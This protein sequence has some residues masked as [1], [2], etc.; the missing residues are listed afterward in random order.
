[1]REYELLYIASGALTEDEAAKVTDEV[2]SAL[3]AV[4]GKVADE[5][6][7]GRRRLAY[8]VAKQEHGW[9]VVSR[10]TLEGSKVT[11]FERALRLN[12]S[13]IRTL[14]LSA[15][16][17]PTAEEAEK[18]AK[19]ASE[20]DAEREDRKEKPK[21][22][23]ASKAPVATEEPEAEAPDEPKHE[24]TEEERQ[25]RQAKLDEKLGELLKEE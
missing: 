9:Y 6:V 4:G 17:V 13:I 19:A 23:A 3:I 7:W 24:E 14:L 22:S 21:R 18:A 20:A 1:M 12:G 8:P 5:N 25:E 2:N 10:I 16:E 11:D 15:D